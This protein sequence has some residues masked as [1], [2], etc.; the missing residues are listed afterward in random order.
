MVSMYKIKR[1][2]LLSYLIFPKHFWYASWGKIY[3]PASYFKDPDK[4]K[5]AAVIE[6]QIMHIVQQHVFGGTILWWF[7]YLLNREFRLDQ[8]VEAFAIELLNAPA[9]DKAEILDKCCL[10]LSSDEY[11]Y[12]GESALL[13]RLDILDKLD[14]IKRNGVKDIKLK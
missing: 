13:I 7:K 1:R 3:A 4:Q 6:H 2:H 9:A 12:A 10:A 14:Q 11:K 8:E 5:Y